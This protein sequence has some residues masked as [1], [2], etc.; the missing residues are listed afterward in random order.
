[1][2]LFRMLLFTI[3][4]APSATYA[5]G[6][7]VPTGPVLLVVSGDLAHT[8]IGDEAHFDYAMLTD[9]GMQEIRT[10]TPWTEGLSRFEGPL[11][12]DLLAAVGARGDNLKVKALNEFVADV[13]VADFREHDVILALKRDGQRMPVRDF[14]PMFVLYPFDQNPD[15][16]N[17]KYRFR[18]VWQVANIHVE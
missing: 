13:P 12:R 11:G 9:L 2:S 8:N 15:L 3:L 16:L 18:S 5:G 14:G 4:L 17:E 10:H 7:P 6:L 1:M